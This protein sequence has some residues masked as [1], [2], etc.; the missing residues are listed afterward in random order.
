MTTLALPT[1]DN[2]LSALE[3]EL[4]QLQ[5]QIKEKRAIKKAIALKKQTAVKVINKLETALLQI[6]ETFEELGESAAE[7]KAI[8]TSK[9][10]EYFPE[11]KT[12]PQ[13]KTE[14]N[15]VEFP[16]TK[17]DSNDYYTWQP[18]S[19]E[20]VS[21]YFNVVKGRVQATYI[22]GN[23]KAR[24]R[25]VGANLI[26]L[27]PNVS[28]ELRKAKRLTSTYELKI[29]GLTDNDIGWLTQFDFTK[30]FY[31]QFATILKTPEIEP[32]LKITE[33]NWIASS[34]APIKHNIFN[35]SC[36]LQEKDNFGE[37][38]A[39][40][41]VTGETFNIFLDDW[42]LDQ[43]FQRETQFTWESLKVCKTKEELQTVKN[44]DTIDELLVKFI[45]RNLPK[46]DRATIDKAINTKAG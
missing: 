44:S 26:K 4:T 17:N 31:P 35:Y 38:I 22:G 6:S 20:L 18:T 15:L 45:W 41:M 21:N 16:Q 23:N 34:T 11:Q 12:E 33:N 37:G 46:S 1:L 25:S 30:D 7:L 36:Y 43:E 19:N 3:L 29:T 42:H 10:S 9:I 2:Q 8:A 32:E 28:F 24:L 40:D 39:K 14:S 27:L 5:E 13:Q